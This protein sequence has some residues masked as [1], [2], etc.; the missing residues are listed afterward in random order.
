MEITRQN[1]MTVETMT[2]WSALTAPVAQTSPKTTHRR[3]V[4]RVLDRAA[5]DPSF[6]AEI[7]ERGSAALSEYRLALEEKAALV[8]GDVRWIESFVG[9][10][11]RRQ[12]TLLNCMLQREAW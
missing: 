4:L 9:K 2:G 3:E 7:A 11:T 6:I 8:S 5:S 10:L 1:T 12:S